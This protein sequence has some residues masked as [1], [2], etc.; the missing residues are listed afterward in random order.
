MFLYAKDPYEAKNQLCIRKRGSVDLNHFNDSKAFIGHS[1]Y[2]NY[3]YEILEEH[4]SNKKQKILIVFD[5]IIADILSTKK[6]QT[7][8]TEF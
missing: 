5:D 3:I 7:I 6:L 4:N 1:N 2:M 8:V